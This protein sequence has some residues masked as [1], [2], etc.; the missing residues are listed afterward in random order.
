MDVMDAW[1]L[2]CGGQPGSGISKEVYVAAGLK[3]AQ[4]L[5][6]DEDPADLEVSGAE[7][8]GNLIYCR[9]GQHFRRLV[10]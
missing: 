9:V 10:Y 8:S 1:W 6:P 7:A 4:M 2:A 5:C 3:M